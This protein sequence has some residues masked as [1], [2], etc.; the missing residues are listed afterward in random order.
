MTR[1]ADNVRE[2]VMTAYVKPARRAGMN[3]VSFTALDVHNGM[4]LQSRMPLVCSSIDAG[5][6]LD[7]AAVTLVRRSGPKQ[8]SS[9]HWVFA[10]KG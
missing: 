9:V 3:T 2:Y 7:F 8:S 1:T 4:R 5:K 10:L 6:F